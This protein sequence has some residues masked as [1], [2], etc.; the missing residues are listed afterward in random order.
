MNSEVFMKDFYPIRVFSL[1]CG[2][3]A[4]EPVSFN[5]SETCRLDSNMDFDAPLYELSISI[6]LLRSLTICSRDLT[7]M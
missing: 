6:F 1:N 4:S 3:P 2:E 7:S 5:Y